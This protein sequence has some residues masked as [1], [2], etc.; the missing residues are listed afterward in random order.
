MNVWSR[1]SKGE[2]KT[3]EK[4]EEEVAKLLEFTVKENIEGKI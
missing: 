4:E 3:G 2:T 1:L